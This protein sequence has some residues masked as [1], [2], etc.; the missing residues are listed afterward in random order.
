MDDDT[1]QRIPQRLQIQ[2]VACNFFKNRQQ[3]HVASSS[4]DFC[5]FVHVSHAFAVKTDLNYLIQRD[6]NR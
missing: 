3:P 5:V 1:A 2:T 4:L 6:T